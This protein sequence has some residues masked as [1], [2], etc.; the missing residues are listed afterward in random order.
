M[1]N[2]DTQLNWHSQSTMFGFSVD[3]QLFWT[4]LNHLWLVL[5]GW[6]YNTHIYWIFDIYINIY[7]IF[8]HS[9]F[10]LLMLYYIY[11]ILITK[12]DYLLII[13]KNLVIMSCSN[14]P[15]WGWNLRTK[16]V[17]GGT[18][19]ESLE[20]EELWKLQV[21]VCVIDWVVW[22]FSFGKSW[23][24]SLLLYESK[25]RFGFS[26]VSLLFIMFCMCAVSSSFIHLL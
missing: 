16:A 19:S 5:Y 15:R 13:F 12:E 23:A 21:H 22:A 17:G 4:H 9:H 25:K 20:F 2:F 1:A 6:S 11:I 8:Q 10:H 26:S 18:V 24:F 14:Y 7:F 3:I